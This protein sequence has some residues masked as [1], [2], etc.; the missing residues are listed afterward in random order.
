VEAYRAGNPSGQLWVDLPATAEALTRIEGWSA[1]GIDGVVLF[2]QAF[3]EKM[4]KALQCVDALEAVERVRAVGFKVAVRMGARPETFAMVAPAARALFPQ[5]VEFELFPV[6]GRGEEKPLPIEAL[7]ETLAR[8]PNLIWSRRSKDFAPPCVMLNAWKRNPSAWREVV[9]RNPGEHDNQITRACGDCG[10]KNYCQWE[11]PELLTTTALESAQPVPLG[12]VP[13]ATE[14]RRSTRFR[15]EVQTT[16][17]TTDIICVTPW[18]TLEITDLGKV[19]QCCIDWT[20]G[21]R[22]QVQEASLMDIWNGPEY[23]SARA[24]MSGGDVGDLCRPIC[25]RLHDRQWDSSRF[26][27]SPG[28]TEFVRNQEQI[29]RDIASGSATTAAKPLQLIINGSSYCNFDCIM[30][31]C[32]RTPRNEVRESLWDEI[33]DLVPFLKGITLLGGEPLA[34]AS[35]MR[36]LRRLK[37]DALPHLSVDLVTNGSLFTPD[38]LAQLNRC[39]LGEITVSVNA[40]TSE[41][42]E[43][44]QRGGVFADTL[45]NIDALLAFREAHARYFGIKLGFVVQRDAIDDLLA[46]GQLADQRNLPIRLLPLHRVVDRPD[47]WFYDDPD[48]VEEIK[49]GL[50]KLRA[51]SMRQRPEWLREIDGVTQSILSEA[52]VA[53]SAGLVILND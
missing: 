4:A 9:A 25:P 51:W 22:G 19:T 47:L 17:D 39:P 45:S 20:H 44:I 32:G 26:F 21:L 13:W 23:Q 16:L 18:T 5:T 42:Y 24:M 53:Q 31:L 35:T 2:V 50:S 41:T 34:N 28:S 36:F 27:M 33:E 6:T 48:T 1:A 14:N 7:E 11:R 15:P 38:G 29:A 8:A 12:T 43:R 3:G 49:E 37:V 46:F 30:C 10:L 52:R 40:G